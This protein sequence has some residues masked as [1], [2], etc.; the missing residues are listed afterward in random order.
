MIRFR[1]L[2]LSV[3]KRQGICF[4]IKKKTA[5]SAFVL[6][7]DHQEH[8]VL[9]ETRVICG[10]YAAFSQKLLKLRVAF[11]HFCTFINYDLE[12]IQNAVFHFH[13]VQ[14]YDDRTHEQTHHQQSQRKPDSDPYFKPA[15]LHR[16]ALSSST[17]IT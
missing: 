15:F 9:Q 16:L 5:G 4:F 11:Y 10:I 14:R 8:I 2:K 17:R 3:L 12:I 13:P 7:V 6:P 1:F